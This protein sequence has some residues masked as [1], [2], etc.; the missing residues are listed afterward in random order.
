M[1]EACTRTKFPKIKKDN[2]AY[3]RNKE[4]K[5]DLNQIVQVVQASVNKPAKGRQ[6]TLLQNG[7]NGYFEQGSF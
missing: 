1:P 2:A 7:D 6:P 4:S 5:K 3:F